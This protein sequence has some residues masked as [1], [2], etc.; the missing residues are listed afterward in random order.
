[1]QP[2]GCGACW[3]PCRGE[4]QAPMLTVERIAQC[5]RAFERPETTPVPAFTAATIAER[6]TAPRCVPCQ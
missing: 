2:N 1:V 3:V 4:T 6:E 5:V